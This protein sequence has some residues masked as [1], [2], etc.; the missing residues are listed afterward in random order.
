MLAIARIFK[1]QAGASL[2]EVA[3]IALLLG[4]SVVTVVTAVTAEVRTTAESAPVR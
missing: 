2:K 4:F 1:R 3:F